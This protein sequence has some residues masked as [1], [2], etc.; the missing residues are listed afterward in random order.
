MSRSFHGQLRLRLAPL[1]EEIPHFL[2]ADSRLVSGWIEFQIDF[3]GVKSP[4]R[5]GERLQL[6]RYRGADLPYRGGS[7]V[8]DFEGEGKTVKTK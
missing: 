6:S 2:L 1:R 3:D 4:L 8:L 5:L 7:I